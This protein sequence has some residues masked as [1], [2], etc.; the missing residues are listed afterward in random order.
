MITNVGPGNVPPYTLVVIDVV[1]STKVADPKVN[2][3]VS[4]PFVEV[5]LVG[6]AKTAPEVISI[7]RT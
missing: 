5:I 6:S 1:G 4:T 7:A 3:C 2:E